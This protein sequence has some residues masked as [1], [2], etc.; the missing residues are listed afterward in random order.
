M[1]YQR[2]SHLACR[3][4]GG[5]LLL[6]CV[7]GPDTESDVDEQTVETEQPIFNSGDGDAGPD[8]AAHPWAVDVG[9]SCSGVLVS[10][11]RV[12]TAAHCVGPGSSGSV[13]FNNVS[14]DTRALLRATIGGSANPTVPIAVQYNNVT[15][16]PGFTPTTDPPDD[17]AVLHLVQPI[18]RKVVTPPA[19]GTAPVGGGCAIR[20]V[21]TGPSGPTSASC[22]TDRI[23]QFLLG[24][25]GSAI[26]SNP[27]TYAG[28]NL[29]SH[30]CLGDS[31]GGVFI[32][33]PS[34]A[35]G[36][37]LVGTLVGLNVATLGADNV[38][39]NLTDSARRLWLRQ[40]ALDLDG[41]G[42][43]AAFDKC[44]TSINNTDGDADG[45]G[46]DCDPCDAD[47]AWSDVDADGALDCADPC[48]DGGAHEDVDMDFIPDCVDDCVALDPDGDG[49]CDLEDNC[50]EA[51]NP[52]QQN[53]N[54][55]AEYG[56]NGSSGL[57]L[58]VEERGDAC[59]PVP[60]ADARAV[61]TVTGG[62]T[63]SPCVDCTGP[64]D[65]DCC[66]G[67]DGSE[68]ASLTC[69][70]SENSQLLVWPYA[71]R[72]DTGAQTS[73]ANLPLPTSGRF[74]Q[75]FPAGG[76]LCASVTVDT[77]FGNDDFDD[78]IDDSAGCYAGCLDP[79]E[80][81][82]RLHRV[83]F[84]SGGPANPDVSVGVNYAQTSRA[85]EPLT[86]TWDYQADLARWRLN[87]AMPLINP[88]ITTAADLR[89]VLAIRT[90]TDL[91]A[92]A[93]QNRLH[94][95]HIAANQMPTGRFD[96]DAAFPGDLNDATVQERGGE[97]LYTPLES[98]SCYQ[99]QFFNIP[100]PLS[101]ASQASVAPGNAPGPKPEP[102]SGVPTTVFEDSDYTLPGAPGVASLA[103]AASALDEPTF[104]LWRHGDAVDIQAGYTGF[105]RSEWETSV[106]VS[107]ARGVLQALRPEGGDCNG[108]LL[109]F[110]E[111]E[112]VRGLLDSGRRW[113]SAA[114]PSSLM[115]VTDPTRRPIA[116][117]IT[118]T[119]AP[120]G[121][122]VTDA[123]WTDFRRLESDADRGVT[124]LPASFALPVTGAALVY[125][126][127]WNRLWVV[128]GDDLDSGRPRGR[129]GF[130][131]LES[132]SEPPTHAPLWSVVDTSYRPSL[133]LASTFDPRTG[134]LFL[135]DEIE[136]SGASG[137]QLQVWLVEIDVRTGVARKLQA[138]ARDPIWDFQSLT[139]DLEGTLILGSGSSGLRAH[140]IS[141]IEI[142]GT[143]GKKK[144]KPKPLGRFSGAGDL[145]V[146]VVSDPEGY[147]VVVRGVKA[148]DVVEG[149]RYGT[150][151]LTATTWRD[152]GLQL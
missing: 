89:G 106:V 28:Q 2:S 83:T 16:Y 139:I 84:S 24:S 95:R 34:L 51:S 141:R 123:I 88:A 50:P 128:G 13:F 54:F 103:L 79:E 11:N 75:V 39:P 122:Q 116:L 82:D 96:V 76:I 114:E 72:S 58:G 115:G 52:A 129:I 126:R 124:R 17:L 70:T 62:P 55:L 59:E 93:H 63:V 138:W 98:Q 110:H 71:Q 33:A 30:V 134:R 104:I 40:N 26:G 66:P 1:T 111:S 145:A 60:I 22:T 53:A 8:G 18:A 147:T 118:E 44:D 56:R 7:D 78:D 91:G 99:C 38:G 25:V 142:A 35:C 31:G 4:L 68:G 101:D 137:T 42:I 3:L 81:P 150:L 152:I 105:G 94:N 5:M 65:F 107:G 77:N 144:T 46:N 97:G 117:G 27:T 41:D 73:P 135:L 90:E 87:P 36:L 85:G 12:L 14:P 108:D 92:V 143:K 74:C 6:G 57:T 132:T 146:P 125:S 119:P 69:T 86:W 151:P 100:E 127:T 23:P 47:P 121:I 45:T 37:Q 102:I 80:Q 149:L 19:V 32:D 10:S 112:S 9:G 136:I 133:A 43:E 49:V 130:R 48:P 148:P 21:A 131:N 140:A 120:V 64:L 20:L 29:G 15:H 61:R 67:F 109:F 113:V